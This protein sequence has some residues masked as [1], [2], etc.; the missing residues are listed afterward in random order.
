MK[1]FASF[2]AVAVVALSPAVFAASGS[3]ARAPSYSPTLS[4]SWPLT[5]ALTTNSSGTFYVVSGCGYNSSLGG[6]T[7]VVTS[8]Y[9]VSSAGQMPDS[10]G[11]ISIS[12]FD[13]LGPGNYHV[14][15]YQ[16]IKNKATLV[17][18]MSFAY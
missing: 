3:A 4:V 11:C 8:P 6:V 16:T 9:A 5:A 15:A 14:D 10:N 12:N 1:R 2:V 7:V 18:S 13:T 17:A